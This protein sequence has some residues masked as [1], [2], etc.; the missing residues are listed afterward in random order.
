[1][2][3]NFWKKKSINSWFIDG[4]IRD[5]QS[6]ISSLKNGENILNSS[7]DIESQYFSSI[8]ATPNHCVI[9][10]LP[11]KFIPKL[12]TDQ[13]TAHLTALPLLEEIKN[14]VLYLSGDSTPNPDGF[15]FWTFISTFLTYK[16][17]VK[18][19]RYFF[20]NNYIM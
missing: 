13:D 8:L 5:K 3:I 20:T 10:N 6:H 4:K 9:N 17:V 14:A 2:E 16:D 11:D 7:D 18:P 12:V 1:M 15:F 19:T